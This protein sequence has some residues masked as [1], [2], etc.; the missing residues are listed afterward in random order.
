MTKR[1]KV[2]IVII[3]SIMAGVY[4]VSP[5]LSLTIEITANPQGIQ[6]FYE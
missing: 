4:I 3:V 5:P 1:K 6:E 2:S